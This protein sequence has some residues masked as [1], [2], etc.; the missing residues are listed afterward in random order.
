MYDQHD[1]TDQEEDPGYLRGDCR[2]PEEAEDARDQPDQE[3]DQRVIEHRRV[4]L[5]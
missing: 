2:D 5:E 1:H 4:L 3:K